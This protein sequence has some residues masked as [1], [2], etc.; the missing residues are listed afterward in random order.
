HQR[1]QPARNPPYLLQLHPI[2]RRD[3]RRVR[4][5]CE[6]KYLSYVFP[7]LLSES[8]CLAANKTLEPSVKAK[9]AKSSASRLRR[10]Y[11]RFSPQ[12][13]ALRLGPD[14]PGSI[15]TT[16]ILTASLPIPKG[17]PRQKGRSRSA[18]W[19]TDATTN[20]NLAPCAA[21]GTQVPHDRRRCL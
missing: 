20:P 14:P 3:Q 6:P 16:A 2:Q 5:D 12:R 18:V 15:E 13:P 8:A 21:P 9:A 10:I 7:E 17:S 19:A 1:Q 11:A 4:E